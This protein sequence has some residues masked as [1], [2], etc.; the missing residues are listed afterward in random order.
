MAWVDIG[1][2]ADLREQTG[3]AG[4]AGTVELRD[5]PLGKVVAADAVLRGGLR[6]LR[7]P[8]EIRGDDAGEQSVMVQAPGAEPLRVAGAGR[9]DQGEAARAPGLDVALLQRSVQR[10]GDTALHEAGRGHDVVLADESDRLLGRNDLVLLHR[11][12]R[13]PRFRSSTASARSCTSTVAAEIASPQSKRAIGPSRSA[14][15]LPRSMSRSAAS[16][17]RRTHKPGKHELNAIMRWLDLKKTVRRIKK[18]SR[19][20]AA[21]RRVRGCS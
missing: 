6:D 16:L 18:N 17:L 1:V 21:W 12:R 7:H 20:A 15:R 2:Q 11:P 14:A 3:L 10:L 4:G 13:P 8:A 5:D 19:E 9:H